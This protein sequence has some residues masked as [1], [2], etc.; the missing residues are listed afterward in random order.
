MADG[1]QYHV[2]Q[3]KKEKLG[4]ISNSMQYALDFHNRNDS[5]EIPVFDTWLKAG[6]SL[7][8]EHLRLNEM[9][10]EFG[11]SIPSDFADSLYK[12][13]RAIIND[14]DYKKIRYDWYKNRSMEKKILESM[15]EDGIFK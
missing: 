8:E 7:Q 6:G 5:V 14:P 12:H 15:S 2:E 3:S 4:K 10:H 1:L 13:N 11:D 9:I